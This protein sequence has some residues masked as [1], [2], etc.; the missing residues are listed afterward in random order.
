M[1]TSLKQRNSYRIWASGTGF[2][3]GIAKIGSIPLKEPNY[4]YL[5]SIDFYLDI[6]HGKIARY[7]FITFCCSVAW[8]SSFFNDYMERLLHSVIHG[9]PSQIN[10]RDTE[11]L[12]SS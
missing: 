7:R 4:S 6:Y 12:P 2:P 1:C 5:P 3:L 11:L 8:I 9:E 10:S